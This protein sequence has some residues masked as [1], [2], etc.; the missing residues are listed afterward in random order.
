MKPRIIL[1]SFLAALGILSIVIIRILGNDPPD[2]A[3]NQARKMLS[4]AELAKSSRYAREQ[5]MQ[6]AAYYDSAM[7]AWSRE[8]ER[9]ILFRNYRGVRDLAGK[10]VESSRN[11]SAL[12][13]RNM[14][15]AEEM[16]EIRM[17][18]LEERMK[19]FEDAYGNFPMNAMHRGAVAQS[20]LQY[21]E[22]ILAFQNKNYSLCRSKLD[23]LEQTLNGLL[24]YHEEL[25]RTYLIEYPHWS[26][27]V[28]KTINHS[29]RN[30][31]CC[32]VVDKLA[33][34]CKLYKDGKLI[35]S[36]AVELG[37]NWVGHKRQQGDKS[38][39]EGMYKISDKKSR[40]QT[41]YYKALMLDYPNEEDKKR[42]LLNKQ[43]GSIH[44][45]ANIGSLIEIHG[46]G[47][48][49]TDWTDG[50]IALKDEDMDVVFNHCSVGSWVTIVGSTK[51]PVQVNSQ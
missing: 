19:E 8:N 34:E 40:G 33:R 18:G 29:R 12:A 1:Y 50:C 9:M 37:P 13:R 15:R 45:D 27:M 6:A 17:H 46:H 23:S 14:V 26:A 22:A 3:V 20:K 25:L 10:S 42:Y 44:Q 51:S 41:A 39:P 36:Y 31:A 5:F 38:T 16:L 2:Q 32:L 7:K 11:A 49:G 28:E 21:S 24:Q 47:G 48:K 35:Q 43:N 30:K 4:E